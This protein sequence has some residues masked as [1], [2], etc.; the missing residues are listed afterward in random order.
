MR[1]GQHTI[2]TRRYALRGSSP[3]AIVQ[4]GFLCAHIIGFSSPQNG[5]KCGSISVK[6]N[7]KIIQ[8]HLNKFSKRLPKNVHAVVIL[9]NA[10]YHKSPKI[11]WPNNVTPWFLPPY[12]PELNPAERPWHH[13]RS[14]SLAG[15]LYKN[16]QEIKRKG[17]AAWMKLTPEILK[18][19]TR[20]PLVRMFD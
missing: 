5:D 7:V 3:R 11:V 15:V 18:S 10:G 13:I 17:Y 4:G 16:I 2:L 1:F 14:R 6:L 19:L 12:S 9:D 8:R 20:T